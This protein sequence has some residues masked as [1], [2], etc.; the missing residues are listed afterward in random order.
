MEVESN[1]CKCSINK[2][3][4]VH[5]HLSFELWM[6]EEKLENT[7]EL[8]VGV[9]QEDSPEKLRLLQEKK[10]ASNGNHTQHRTTQITT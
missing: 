6:H 4:I 9:T 8:S 1:L 5:E 7:T 10:M 3:L 2:W